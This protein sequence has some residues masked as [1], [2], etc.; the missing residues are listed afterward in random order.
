MMNKPVL[1]NERGSLS[2]IGLLVVLVIGLILVLMFMKPQS[3]PD[4]DGAHT[5]VG[6]SM[7]MA[8]ETECR[9]NLA[10]IRS[11]ITMYRG[12]H[13]E[14]A[15][16]SLADVQLGTASPDF[17]RCPVGKED[18][19]YDAAAGSIRCPHPGHENY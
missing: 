12:E 13:E 19:V 6:R 14:A 16:A 5:T 9:S 7:N 4:K 2:L 17:V 3:K 18:Y 8:R 10:Q 11:A 1:D 15:P